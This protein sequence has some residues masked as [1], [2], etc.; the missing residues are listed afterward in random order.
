MVMIS[1]DGRAYKEAVRLAVIEQQVMPYAADMRLWM[2]VLV[3]RADARRADLDNV[4]KGLQDAMEADEKL[5]WPGVYAND[6][7]IDLLTVE[8]GMK[9]KRARVIVSIGELGE[10]WQGLILPAVRKVVGF[11]R[12]AEND[13]ESMAA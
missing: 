13:D 9:S 1:A 12:P 8:R 2:H 11:S 6:G 7:Q 10:G 4:L 3:E 5:G